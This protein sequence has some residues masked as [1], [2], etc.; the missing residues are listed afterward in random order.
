MLTK[1][2]LSVF[3]PAARPQVIHGMT[4]RDLLRVLG[5]NQFRVDME[6]ADRLYYLLIIGVLNSIYGTWETILSS[7][8]LR[9]VEINPSPLFIL[10]HWRSG[11]THLHNLLSLDENFTS[12]TA[13]Q[14]LFPH[15]FLFTGVAASSFSRV[16]PDK[17]PMDNVAFSAHTPH[18]D[19]FAIAAH[20]TVS[21]YMKFLFPVTGDA[22]Y[23]EIDPKRLPKKEFQRWKDSLILFMKKITLLNP[24]RIVLKSPPHLGRVST[25]LEIF[26]KAQFIHIV[27]DPYRVY[28]STHKLWSDGLGPAHLQIPKPELV[29]EII[30]SWYVELFSLFERDKNLIPE[31]SLHEMKFEDL[32]AEP[33]ETL[34]KMYQ[35]LGLP[36]F[37]SFE[38]RLDEY[39][40][41]IASYEKNIFKM[42]EEDR[43]KVRRAWG[44]NF[45]LYGYPR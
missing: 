39:L 11:T 12:P 24:G 26:P 22:L 14:S 16:A 34:R 30:L 36:G 8:Q 33:V 3:N 28:L 37:D 10:G 40:K 35:G 38:T 27:R 21:P 41:S 31:G 19:E 13:F 1:I 18:E 15:H 4:L 20:S 9:G 44:K 25:L 5:R 32:E 2:D 29:D 6:C 43:E 23:S 17:R 7:R 45:D 42:S